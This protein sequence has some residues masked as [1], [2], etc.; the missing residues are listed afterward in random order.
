[1]EL[2]ELVVELTEIVV[3]LTELEVELTELEVEL[4]EL[5][6][7]LTELVVELT[8]L[9]VEL[10][11]LVVELTE[12]V[13]E[14]TEL[15]TNSTPFKSIFT[16]IFFNAQSTSYS[17][18]LEFNS[19]TPPTA[20][21]PTKHQFNLIH[22]SSLQ[23]INFPP[24]NYSPH[25]LKLHH[26]STISIFVFPHNLHR[27]LFVISSSRDAHHQYCSSV[28]INSL[29]SPPKCASSS[30]FFFV[31]SSPGVVINSKQILAW[32]IIASRTFPK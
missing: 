16:T 15:E 24:S 25:I 22:S 30:W 12:L 14:L 17:I 26:L 10:T 19:T 1:V 2:T 6:V 21:H 23:F 28:T 5:E 3:E 18:K 20:F 27:T 32:E 31:G 29:I 9:E 4:T 8:E 7:E 11:E 13:V